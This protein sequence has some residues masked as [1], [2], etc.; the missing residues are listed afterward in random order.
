MSAPHAD[1]L[2]NE[3]LSR[4][5]SALAGVPRIRRE[6]ILDEITNHIA[7]ERSRLHDESDADLRNLLDRVGDPAEV[8]DAARD[9]TD[10]RPAPQPRR[11]GPVEVLALVL[12]PLI[13]PAGVIL[14]WLSPAWKLRDK[15]IGALLPPGGYWFILFLPL[16]MLMSLQPVA[17]GG[18]TSVTDSNGT[19]ISHTCTGYQSMPL[20]QQDVMQA[21]GVGLFLL[22]LVLPVLTAIYLAYR[23]RKW[24]AAP[25]A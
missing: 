15:L 9:E 4:L 12:T 19:V 2:V 3:Y 7:E 8:A 6:E 10:E 16:I 1:Q 18:C 21:A 20:W 22:L 13:W 24:S 14:L 17:G 23:A 11:I 5:D 25:E